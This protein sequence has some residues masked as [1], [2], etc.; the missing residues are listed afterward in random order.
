MRNG[1]YP[2]LET[3]HNS[4]HVYESDVFEKLLNFARDTLWMLQH[5]CELGFSE[6]TDALYDDWLRA[7]GYRNSN[8]QTSGKLLAQD[9]AGYYGQEFL[10]LLNAYNSGAYTWIW[11]LTQL[12]SFRHP[13]YQLLLIRFLAGYPS[14]FFEGTRQKRPEH[15]PYGAPPYPCRNVVCEHY[16]LDVIEHI[17]ITHTAKG[18]YK[19]AFACPH[20]GFVYRRKRPI[21]KEKQ[22]AGQIDITDYGWLWQKKVAAWLTDGQSPY[23]IARDIHCDV[24][25]V[26]SFGVDCGLLPPERR[27]GRKPYIPA[28][29]PHER[30]DFE[31]RRA[32]Y[33]QRWR[34]AMAANPSI[35][36]KGLMRL[37]STAY[38]WLHLYDADWL[39]QNSPPSRLGLPQWAYCDDE[40]LKKVGNALEEIRSSPSIPRRLSL[41]AIG[42]VA[43]ISKPYI[44][45]VSEYL[46]ATKALVA[47]NVE[48]HEQWQKRKI[49]WA[50][51][52]M[53]DCG[54]LLT[55][56]KVRHAANIEDRERKLDGF[57]EECILNS[58]R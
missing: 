47:A 43:G 50:V 11:S 45:L 57:I 36:R 40:Y 44:R 5:G 41:T 32:W 14:S 3:A 17:E 39:E 23:K 20:C 25:T 58:E 42:R 48:T 9:V 12:N 7:K 29:L 28:L 35:T 2:L 6:D 19:A 52:K 22:Y 31:A 15:L 21:T 33:R 26:L 51:R 10:S 34:E 8:G 49:L 4:A 1:Y 13:L 38:Q 16:L 54:E 55:V 30:L 53:R 56:Y 27:M 24:R 18:A 46:P 37:D